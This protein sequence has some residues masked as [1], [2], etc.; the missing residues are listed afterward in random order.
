M[1]GLALCAAALSISLVPASFGPASKSVHV[2]GGQT[3]RTDLL[4]DGSDAS[5]QKVEGRADLYQKGQSLLAPIQKDIFVAKDFLLDG[6]S[7]AGRTMIPWALSV[8]EVKRET[9]MLLRFRVKTAGREWAPAGE[10]AVHVYPPGFS[11]EALAAWSKDRNLHVFGKSSSLRRFLKTQQI[12]FTDEGEEFSLP[13]DASGEKEF[14]VGDATA[15]EI[16]KCF[17]PH[18]SWPGRVAVICE[19]S[20]LLPGVY[21]SA[22]GRGRLLKVT[23]PLLETLGSNPQ[24]QKT[25]LH[26]LD[27]LAAQ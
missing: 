25:F 19:D 3:V 7:A 11:K 16:T 5:P 27:T 24:N 15:A 8:P 22:R 20:P 4:V 6:R 26:I 10:I 1:T 9:G 18:S 14:Y 13:S 21:E 23:L 2:F 17:P 12:E